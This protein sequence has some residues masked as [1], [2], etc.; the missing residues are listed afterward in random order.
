MWLSLGKLVKSLFKSI[1]ST[2]VAYTNDCS[3]I[4]PPSKTA[5][6]HPCKVEVTDYP[7]QNSISTC[8]RLVHPLQQIYKI[9]IAVKDSMAISAELPYIIA[10]TIC[11]IRVRPCV[12]CTCN[13]MLWAVHGVLACILNTCYQFMSYFS[14]HFCFNAVLYKM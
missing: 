10:T 8:K 6:V 3:Y 14:L 11:D 1:C 7:N 13:G 12:W 9:S 2:V 4:Y 5:R